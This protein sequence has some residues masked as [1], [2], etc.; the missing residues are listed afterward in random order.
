MKI[1]WCMQKNIDID[2]SPRLY[3]FPGCVNG[4]GKDR[5]KWYETSRTK[6][7]K[8]GACS[9]SLI[10]TDWCAQIRKLTKSA[11]HVAVV[12]HMAYTLPHCFQ[13]F[14]A[15][16][17]CFISWMVSTLLKPRGISPVNRK[18]HGFSCGCWLFISWLVRNL[19]PKHPIAARVITCGLNY[20][21]QPQYPLTAAIVYFGC[22]SLIRP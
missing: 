12:Y 20:L 5:Q 4:A 18:Q 7:T 3:R 16:D 13:R 9:E 14:Q 8:P 22:N 2:G 11:S 1:G 19:Q 17:V 6:F 21:L 15:M 10:F